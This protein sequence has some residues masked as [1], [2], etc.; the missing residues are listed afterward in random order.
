MA[1]E[2]A[3]KLLARRVCAALRMPEVTACIGSGTPMTPVDA[4][5]TSA[6]AE[7]ESFAGGGDHRAGVAAAFAS[8]ARVGVAA[9]DDDGAGPTF[10]ASQAAFG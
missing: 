5:R 6:D 7:A 10:A 1:W 9:V 2:N 4:T 3:S 8:R